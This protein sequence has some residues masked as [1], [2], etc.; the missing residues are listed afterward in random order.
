M[1]FH[2]LTFSD[3]KIHVSALWNLIVARTALTILPFASVWKH[4]NKHVEQDSD[5]RAYV[6]QTVKTVAQAVERIA[7]H[8]PGTACLPRALVVQKMLYNYGYR[9]QIHIGARKDDDGQFTAHAWVVRDEMII[10]GYL[11]NLNT[12]SA[13]GMQ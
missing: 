5:T 13:F 8:I 1:K 2:Q 3:K 11:D 10:I 7:N 9:S 12:F 6:D 4:Y